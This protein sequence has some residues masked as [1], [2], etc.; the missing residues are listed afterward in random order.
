[1]RY[2]NQR[3]VHPGEWPIRYG[4]RLPWRRCAPLV[5]TVLGVA[6]WLW[7]GMATWPAWAGETPQ[8]GGTLVYGLETEPGVLDPHT[9]GPWATARVVM[10]IFDALVTVDTSTGKSP[11]PIVG[12][13][14]ERWVMSP[15]GKEYT[16]FLRKG[17]KFHDGT[18]FNAEAVK[19]N[20]E[21][22]W[23]ED[24]PWFYDRA[25]SF[26]RMAF[27]WVT[28]VD[29]LDEFTVRLKLSQPF[30]D[31]IPYLA[32]KQQPSAIISPAA[33]KKHGNK[34]IAQHPIGSGP[35]EF[36][37]QVPNERTVLKRFD[38]YWGKKPAL[39][40]IIIRP[41]PDPA[42]RVL[43][44]QTGEVDVITIPPPDS[45]DQLIKQGYQWLQGEVHHTWLLNLNHQNQYF[46][47][48]R[49]RQAVCYGID[50][51]G[52]AKHVLNDT[53]IPAVHGI[54]MP[55]APSWDPSFIMYER[56]PAKAKQLLAEAG[57]ANG[58]KTIF[59]TST[60]GSGQLLPVPMMEYLQRNLK[61]VGID[62]EIQ[63]FEWLSY[64]GLWFKGAPPEVGAMQQSTGRSFDHILARL[65]HSEND[66]PVGWNNGHVKNPELDKIMD[67]AIVEPDVAKAQQ[68]WRQAVRLATEECHIVPVVH[69]LMPIVLSP[70]VKG[71]VFPHLEWWTYNDVWLEK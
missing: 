68:L 32:D 8:K 4:L 27:R 65:M 20:I 50:R 69:D 48:K 7:Q 70:K 54:T 51:Q 11:P 42:A 39:D 28:A 2:H 58:F 46:K 53:V 31:F 45:K 23:K 14:A 24:S 59:Q 29:V 60:A 52:L 56:D 64:V 57:Y 41:L 22:N 19:V 38:G 63:S 3:Q 35:F 10:H 6:V 62:V 66:A 25:Q 16:F 71:F 34:G 40:R 17:V 13:L 5:C 30:S 36:V 9:F 61:E 18:D 37:E 15:D 1:M 43:A 47:D 12:Q 21:R 67:A 33:I 49:I 44:L 55:T 26:T